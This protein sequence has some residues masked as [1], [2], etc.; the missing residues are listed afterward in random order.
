MVVTYRESG[1]LSPAAQR[2]V[3]LLARHG[4]FRSR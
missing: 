3:V 2:L 4:R 1:Y